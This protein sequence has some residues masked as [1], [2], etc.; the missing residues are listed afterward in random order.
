MKDK[1]SMASVAKTQ[2]LNTTVTS[3]NKVNNRWTGFVVSNSRN[4]KVT[5]NSV[6]GLFIRS[7]QVGVLKKTN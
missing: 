6:S 3:S 2:Q 4:I 1:V 5:V 7:S